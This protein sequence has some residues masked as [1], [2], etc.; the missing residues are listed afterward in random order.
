MENNKL[1]LTFNIKD[2]EKF[3]VERINIFGNYQTFEEVI[4]NKL[5]VDEG[6]PLNN[7]L[8]NKSIDEIKSLRIFKDV[9]ADIKNGSDNNQ[10]IIDITVQEQPTGEISL[11]AGVGTSGSTIGGGIKE[12]NFLGKGIDL[13]TNLEISE[14]TIKGKFIY[15]KPNFAYTDNTLSTSLEATTSDFLTDFGYKL[16]T[17][18]GS[19]GTEFEQY[20]NLFFSPEI[21]LSIE[22]L[23]TNSTAS[24]QLRKQEG[25]YEDIY[26]NYG[27]NYDLRNS[28]Y[29]PSSGYSASFFQQLPIISGNNEIVNTLIYNKYKLINQQSN[30]VGKA[31]VYLKSVHSLDSSDVRISK[32]AQIPER[33]LRGFQQGK[34]GPKDGE[35][36]VGG[37]YISAINLST[38]LP[39]ILNTVESLDFT[40]FIDLANVWGVDYDETIDESNT[41]RS[42]T[43][44]GL[45][46]LT[47]IGPLSFT[48]SQP[49]TKNSSD[50]TE[51]FRF[52]IGTTF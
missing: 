27:L 35:D 40:Y 14:D 31:S 49:I 22:E 51:T 1:N 39:M 28:S 8:F 24:N 15:S 43:G 48:F 6:D 16:T 20:E 32:R 45:D 38:N 3:Y 2:S 37:N 52:N 17:T 19:I 25:T 41:L 34:I 11:A 30:M 42:S 26:F 29:K 36:Y 13:S 18:G 50:K 23:S 21:S 46:F 33:R 5:I 47:P 4:R 10:K 44:I 12:K 7:L 9:K